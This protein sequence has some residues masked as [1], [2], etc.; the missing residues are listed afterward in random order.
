MSEH[1]LTSDSPETT[2][3]IGRALGEA[4][5]GGAFVALIGPLGAGKT[6]LVQGLAEGLG[7]EESARSPSYV[8]VHEYPGRRPMI[9]CDWHR[10]ETD[11]DVESTGFED[12]ARPGVVVAVEWADKHPRWL[13][14]NR[15]EIELIWRGAERRTLRLRAVG[16]GSLDAVVDAVVDALE[17]ADRS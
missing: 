8:L 6:C 1:A 11:A 3:R 9:H 12:L 7:C 14:P 15:L 16:D 13:P 17:S 5:S 4:L 10:L 2:R